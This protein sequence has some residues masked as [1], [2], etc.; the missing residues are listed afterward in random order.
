MPVE[1]DVYR[2]ELEFVREIVGGIPKNPEVIKAWVMSRAKRSGK[3]EEEAKKLVEKI[4]EEV[5]AD[6]EAE[7]TWVTFKKDENGLYLEDRNV[8]AMFREAFSVLGLFSGKGA[9]A[10]KQLF[11]HGF[12]IKPWRIYFKR[13]GKLIREPDGF[14]ERTIH[15]MTMLG[16]RS[17]LK[18][19]DYVKPPVTVEFEVWIVKSRGVITEEHLRDALEVA[20]EAIGLGAS[21][22][23]GFGRFK[24]VKFKSKKD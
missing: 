21:R 19:E 5:D 14:H 3:T 23:Q 12:V 6:V 16:P 11:Q 18:R 1:W 24:V 22:S 10:R 9:I 20:S 7:K 8:K 15:V 2:V 13:N 4:S 17:A